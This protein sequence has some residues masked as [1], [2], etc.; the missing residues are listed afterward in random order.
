MRFDTFFH[1]LLRKRVKR[2]DPLCTHYTPER[3]TKNIVYSKALQKTQLK[4]NN[5]FRLN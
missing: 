4:R 1:G 5:E 2:E 3:K